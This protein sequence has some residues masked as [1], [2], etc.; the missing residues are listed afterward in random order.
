M[1]LSRLIATTALLVTGLFLATG[2]LACDGCSSPDEEELKP[3]RFASDDA[4]YQVEFPSHWSPEPVENI[5]PHADIAAHRED[6]YFFMVITQELPTFPNPDI[7]ELKRRA[8]EMLDESV[9]NLVI[10]SQGP[11][12]LDEVSGLT[13]FARGE[14]DGDEISYI[15]SYVIRDGI[16]YQIVAFTN[17]DHSSTLFEETDTILSSWS[18]TDDTAAGPEAATEL[19]DAGDGPTTGPLPEM[20]D[21]ADSP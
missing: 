13:V 1:K 16:G 8:L 12:D 2:L 3:W 18:F 10:E 9:D 6:T 17:R 21:T 7:L 20:D 14:V 11:L 4:A 19:E 5:N 15:T